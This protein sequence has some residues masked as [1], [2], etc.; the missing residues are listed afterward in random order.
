MCIARSLF[1]DRPAPD[2]HR[3]RSLFAGRPAPD[4]RPLDVSAASRVPVH[5]CRVPSARC[6]S[7]AV[8]RLLRAARRSPVLPRVRPV[9]RRLSAR[10]ARRPRFPGAFSGPLLSSAHRGGRLLAIGSA[11][12]HSAESLSFACRKHVRM[13]HVKHWVPAP[14]GRFA[15]TA[16]GRRRII[17]VPAHAGDDREA[18]DLLFPIASAMFHVK[19]SYGLPVRRMQGDALEGSRS[20]RGRTA[21]AARRRRPWGRRRGRGGPRKSRDARRQAAKIARSRGTRG[22]KLRSGRGRA[23]K[24]AGRTAADCEGPGELRSAPLGAAGGGETRGDGSWEAAG[25][26]AAGC[27]AR[28]G[29]PW[30][31]VG[32]AAA[33]SRAASDAGGR[34]RFRPRRRSDTYSA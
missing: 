33:F 10:C 20:G 32:R 30:E 34:A 7:R 18:V 13:F 14:E 15:S 26:A 3:A 1:T 22:G 5:R 27:R 23:A 29:G 6:S 24:A 21:K 31:G 16:G 28:G 2:V 12:A 25:R 11:S 17:A 9:A 8:W 4:A 19:H